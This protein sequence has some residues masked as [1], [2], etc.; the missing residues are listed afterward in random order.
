M[1]KK[2]H[3]NYRKLTQKEMAFYKLYTAFREE[4]GRWVSA[5]EFVGEMFV[6]ELNLWVLMSYKTPTNGLDIFFEN[7][8]LLE[9]QKVRGKSGSRYYQYRIAPNP[10]PEKIKDDALF[11]FYKIIKQKSDPA[12]KSFTTPTKRSTGRRTT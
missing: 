1:E 7:P 11:Q 3:R 5:W 8:G 6:K 12:P 4:P 10:A 2:R 9:R